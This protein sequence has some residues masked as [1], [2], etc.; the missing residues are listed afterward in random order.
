MAAVLFEE[1]A[2]KHVLMLSLLSF[3]A[4]TL[5]Q[6]PVEERAIPQRAQ[7]QTQLK[8]DFA[9]KEKEK[10]AERVHQAKQ[11]LK[12]T[13]RAQAVAEKQ[14]EAAKQR[15]AIAQKALEKAQADLMQA[16]ARAKQTEAEAE[17]AW[18]K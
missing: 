18:R 15:S 10:A 13:Q 2:V 9:R 7:T 14:L 17:Q 12:E 3:S 4:A 8:A 6:V 5:A 11:D 1:T 16:E